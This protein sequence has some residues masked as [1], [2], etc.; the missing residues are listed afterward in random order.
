[1]RE[2]RSSRCTATTG[3]APAPTGAPTPRA[4]PI[5]AGKLTRRYGYNYL[6]T[7]GPVVDESFEYGD[8]GGRLSKLT[9]STGNG[10]LS[11]T[12]SQTWSYDSLGL[13]STHN[14]P[15]PA[16][17]AG[18]PVAASY[19]NG[20]PT[21]LTGNGQTVVAAAAYGPSAALA[22]WTAGN[23]G[24]PVVTTIAPDPSLLPRPA[25]ISNAL[26]SSGSYA[27]DGA[28]D[29]L[30]IGSSDNFAYDSR[31]RLVSAKYGTTTRGFGYDR[32]GNL[33][34]NGAVS[35]S[36]DPATNRVTSGGRR[37]TTPAAT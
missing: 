16:G 37:N 5:P 22:S 9:T 36:I 32:W 10:D 3:R 34:Q 33:T 31:A 13:P 28:G 11:A 23:A 12:V 20:L 35:F 7:I 15:R 19:V 29:I 27:Y 26:W 18:F 14:H 6:P 1:M 21:A 30:S 25:S 2:A 24:A 4:A 17:A 8:G